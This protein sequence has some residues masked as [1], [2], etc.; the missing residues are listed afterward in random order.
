MLSNPASTDIEKAYLHVKLHRDD[1]DYIWFYWLKE[2]S[3]PNGQFD[4][5]Q[6]KA[7]LF[8][9]VNSSFILYAT[10]YLHLQQYNTP[11][12]HDILNNLY[13]D[14]ILSGCSS[15]E[16]IIRYYHNARAILSEAWEHGQPTV[17]NLEALPKSKRQ[18][19]LPYQTISWECYG[20]QFLTCSQRHINTCEL[21]Y[22]KDRTVA[23]IFKG[24]WRH[25]CSSPSHY[26]SQIAS[27]EGLVSTHRVG[28]IS[29]NRI[30]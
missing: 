9:A 28:Q 5:Y 22:N 14:N 26:P 11:L 23:G 2:V 24:V 15:E 1:R 19:T 7:V 6:F 21:T 18:L 13:V 3:N 20:I 4:V 16:E 30:V 17:R 8:S 29:R 27:S 12:S 10:L 25:E